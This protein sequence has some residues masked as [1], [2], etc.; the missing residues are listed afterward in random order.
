MQ[1][2]NAVIQSA[3]LVCTTYNITGEANLERVVS[4]IEDHV[5]PLLEAETAA[6]LSNCRSEIER[7]RKLLETADSRAY[8]RARRRLLKALAST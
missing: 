2:K 8:K 7:M 5:V 6:R 3:R 1:F 4:I